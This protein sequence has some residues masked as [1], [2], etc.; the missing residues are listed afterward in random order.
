MPKKT[1]MVCIFSPSLK[2]FF[3]GAEKLRKS[4]CC[5]AG[6]ELFTVVRETTLMISLTEKTERKKR[7]SIT[8]CIPNA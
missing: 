8:E 3:S 6:F 2:Q 4:F 1:N 5:N 7:G